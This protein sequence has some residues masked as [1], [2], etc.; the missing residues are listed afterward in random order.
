MRRA[1]LLSATA[2]LAVMATPVLAQQATT[3]PATA[4]PQTAPAQPTTPPTL[5]ADQPAATPAAETPRAVE[6]APPAAATP[7]TPATADT[8]V[9]VLRG[10]AQFS[11]L[12]AA[13][14]AAQLTETLRTNPAISIFAPTDAAFAAL[15]EA[16]RTR[17]MDPANINDLR[18]LLLFHVIVADVNS[19]D[20][21][22]RRGQVETAA[23]TPVQL[24]GTGASLRIGEATITQADIGASNGAVF[25]IDRVLAPAGAAAAETGDEEAAPGASVGPA[26]EPATAAAPASDGGY[27]TETAPAA[28][29]Q[30]RPTDS[31]MA[32]AGAPAGGVTTRP[33]AST[34]TAPDGRVG[35]ATTTA[36]PPIVS[37]T[38]GQQDDDA[39]GEPTSAPQA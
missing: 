8:V 34:A 36:A 20:I 1:H 26:R 12:V 16:E 18:Q 10:Q 38:D 32:P 30:V 14:D 31:S 7:I 33:S 6:S 19:S 13:L 35:P 22:G 3:S 37:P 9:D 27:T 21:Q 39:D 2:V 28:P 11:T 24:D 29:G 23:R 4:T 5:P 17:L 15:A 25:V